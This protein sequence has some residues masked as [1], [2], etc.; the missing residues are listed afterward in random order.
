MIGTEFSLLVETDQKKIFGVE[1]VIQGIT[2]EG[3]KNIIGIE[4]ASSLPRVP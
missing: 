2:E 3:H 1:K 4:K